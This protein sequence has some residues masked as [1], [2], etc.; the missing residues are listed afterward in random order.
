MKFEKKWIFIG[1]GVILYILAIVSGSEIS[2]VE[3]FFLGLVG[4]LYIKM[5]KQVKKGI[6]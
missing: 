4:F 1:I 3:L 6:E 5:N 2:I